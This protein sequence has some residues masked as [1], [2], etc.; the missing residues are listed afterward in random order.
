VENKAADNSP[1]ARVVLW[2]FS[3]ASLG[4]LW[5]FQAHNLTVASASP[6]TNCC[7]ASAAWSPKLEHSPAGPVY[8][9]VLKVFVNFPIA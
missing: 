4:L 8:L 6:T 1:K 7:R 5:G 9:D 3:G 2:G